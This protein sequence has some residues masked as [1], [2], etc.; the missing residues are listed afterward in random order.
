MALPL[1]NER[2]PKE[3]T[4]RGKWKQSTPTN[5]PTNLIGWFVELLLSS[6]RSLPCFAPANQK[7]F[8]LAGGAAAGKK[9]KQLFFSLSI[10]LKVDGREE[11]WFFFL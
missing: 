10:K 2:G 11:S 6:L 5:Q 9:N 1:R 8:E 7:T 3:L 4:L